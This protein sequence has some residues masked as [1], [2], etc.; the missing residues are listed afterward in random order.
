MPF[1]ARS[2]P[3]ALTGRRLFITG[4]TGFVGRSLLDY[5][6]ESAAIHGADFVVTILSRQPE[7][8]FSRFPT[9]CGLPWLQVEKGEL[10]YLPESGE[11]T[12]LIH[13]AAD[14]HAGDDRIA[15]FDQLVTGTRN[16]LSF[17]ARAGVKRSLFISSGAVY[18]GKSGGNRPYEDDAQLAPA[19]N[20]TRTIY[21][22]GKR[23]AEHLCALFNHQYDIG[24]VIARLFTVLSPHMPL[25]GPYAAGNFIR[26][27]LSDVCPAIGISGNPATLRSYID[28]RDMAHWLTVLLMRGIAG[29]AYNV[30]SDEA[31]SIAALAQTIPFALGMEKDV[32]VAPDAASRPQSIYVP[33]ITKAKGLGLRIETGIEDA[34]RRAA[35]PHRRRG[36]LTNK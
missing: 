18:G 11:Y 3:L 1:A 20:D 7:A 10:D 30:G 34:I 9:Y 17:A 8:F 13:A 16:T 15:W 4:G 24:C 2:K 35:A 23:A 22:Q 12:D 28:G 26:D 21:G 29:E 27:T 31:I 6:S 14:T 36:F 5:F 32:R 25:D 33:A 19:L